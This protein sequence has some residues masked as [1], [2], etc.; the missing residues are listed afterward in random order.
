MRRSRHHLEVNQ[1]L[2]E[3][4]STS[5]SVVEDERLDSD[6]FSGFTRPTTHGTSATACLRVQ[7]EPGQRNSALEQALPKKLFFYFPFFLYLISLFS[8]RPPPHV[9]TC[10][11]LATPLVF[12]GP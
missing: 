7:G 11:F 8:D 5:I 10:V 2:G 1:G 9:F 4:D 6:L 12:N 3:K